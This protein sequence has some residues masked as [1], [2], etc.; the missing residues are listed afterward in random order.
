MADYADRLTKQAGAALGDE[1]F[2]VAIKCV[3]EGNLRR[4]GLGGG[5]FGVI[6]ATVAA[7]GTKDGHTI[8]DEQLPKELALGLTATRLFVFPL[9]KM[10]G[11]AGPVRLVVPVEQIVGVEAAPG[12][13]FGI[14]QVDLAISFAD[15]SQLR[16]EVPRVNY[17]AGEQFA[18]G[19]KAATA[20]ENDEAED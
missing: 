3:A 8:G 18:A 15:G 19:L 2:S 20:G 12:K 10:T 4:K 6:G 17:A 5:L 14:K 9:S 1:A 16:V 13:T 7:S 11:K